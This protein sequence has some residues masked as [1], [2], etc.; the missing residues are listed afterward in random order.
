MASLAVPLTN[1][2]IVLDKEFCISTTIM[3][4]FSD[5]IS[6]LLLAFLIENG[7]FKGFHRAEDREKHM[8]LRVLAKSDL[9]SHSTD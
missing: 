5:V 8:V 4:I 7:I 3:Y 6:L 2:E 1:G 9:G